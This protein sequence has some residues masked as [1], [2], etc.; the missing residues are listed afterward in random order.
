MLR[1]G[2]RLLSPVAVD[3]IDDVKPGMKEQELAAKIDWRIK[4]AGLRAVL[5]RDDRRER[6][7]FG[8]P[9]RPCRATGS[10]REGTSWCWT[11]A[12]STAD[13]AST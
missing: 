4:S 12:G 3:V 5:V 9:A 13:T 8:P 11:L 7:Q 10:L 1:R 6:P 2:A